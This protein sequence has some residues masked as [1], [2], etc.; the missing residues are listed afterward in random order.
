M[1][2]KKTT[3]SPNASGELNCR[4]LP[5]SL[6][7]VL[8]QIVLQNLIDC[9]DSCTTAP[10]V[11]ISS[12]LPRICTSFVHRLYILCT[13]FVHPPIRGNQGRDRRDID[14]ARPPPSRRSSAFLASSVRPSHQYCRQEDY[15][16]WESLPRLPSLLPRFPPSILPPGGLPS[17]G[18]PPPASLAS[19][20]VPPIN[21]ATGA[22]TIRGNSFPGFPRFFRGSPHQYCR[23]EDYHPWEFLPRL[24]SLLPRLLPSIP[25][26]GDYH[27]WESL[28]RLPSLLLRFPPSILPPGRLPSVGIPSPGLLIARYPPWGWLGPL[29]I[30]NHSPCIATPVQYKYK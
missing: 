26:P 22:I 10:R 1:K 29:A 13:S 23:Q 24:P 5:V 14:R 11:C 7:T 25:L 28:P 6:A 15:R 8:T 21:I 3:R 4:P 19:S 27:P 17:V 16:P 9:R 2:R 20:A 12:S 30:P 18:I